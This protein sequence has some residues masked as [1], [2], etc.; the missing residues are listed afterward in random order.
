MIFFPFKTSVKQLLASSIAI[1]WVVIL[2]LHVFS[3][4]TLLVYELPIVSLII[5]NN[6]RYSGTFSSKK[7]LSSVLI[8]IIHSNESL[9]NRFVLFDLC[10]L[11]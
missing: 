6:I 10:S 1:Q 3:S 4:T 7:S 9:G 8:A 2:S 5:S 11:K